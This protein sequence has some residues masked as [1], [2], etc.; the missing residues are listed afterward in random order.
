MKRQSS[1][2]DGDEAKRR[3]AVD[4]DDDLVDVLPDDEDDW[5]ESAMY[6]EAMGEGVSFGAR[7]RLPVLVYLALPHTFH[8]R[9]PR[10]D[11]ITSPFSSSCSR[12]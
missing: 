6:M 3:K 2:T 10:V 8:A 4:D 5:D 11:C 12:G 9:D 7:S 1:G